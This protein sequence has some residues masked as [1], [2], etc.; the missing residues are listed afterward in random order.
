M[1][2][3]YSEMMN[4]LENIK[5]ALGEVETIFLKDRSVK[6]SRFSRSF[7][8][9]LLISDRLSVFT[10]KCSSLLKSPL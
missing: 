8:E 4:D 1:K 3:L 7:L 2:R 6:W 5:D 9:K 10:K